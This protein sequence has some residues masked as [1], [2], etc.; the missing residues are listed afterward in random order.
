MV[1]VAR[2]SATANAIDACVSARSVT[3]ADPVDVRPGAL[4]APAVA[5]AS[6][7]RSK[8]RRSIGRIAAISLESRYDETASNA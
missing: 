2:R 5:V 1:T 4:T 3:G 8:V 6:S 7:A